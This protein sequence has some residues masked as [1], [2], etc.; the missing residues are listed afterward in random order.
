MHE[1]VKYVI[2]KDIYENQDWLT[3]IHAAQNAL[4]NKFIIVKVTCP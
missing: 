1:V 3:I 4:S 2:M